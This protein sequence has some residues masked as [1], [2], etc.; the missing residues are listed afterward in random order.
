MPR[1]L[2]GTETQSGRGR[3]WHEVLGRLSGDF[4]LQPFDH[5][6]H[7]L[8]RRRPDAWLLDG[9]NGPLPVREPQVIQLHEA[10]WSEPETLA[11]LEPEFI[12]KV[13]GPSRRAAVAASAVVCPSESAK[14]QIVADC[15]V[16]PERVFV[17]LHGVDHDVFRPG[18]AG[19]PGVASRFGADP[20]RPYVLT[21]ASFH[22]R[23]NL[24]TLRSAFA[25]LSDL[26]HQLVIVGGP[27]HGRTDGDEL[28]A[29]I[30]VDLPNDPRRI[31]V[32]P[33]GIGDGDLAALMCGA[34]AFCLPSLSEGFGL[35][36]AEAMACGTPAV[37]S[38]RGALPEIGGDTAIL[39]EP[40][41]DAIAQGLRPVLVDPARAMA[42]GAACTRRAADFTWDRC[43]DH[44]GVAI[45]TAVAEG[46]KAR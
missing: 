5:V 11:T 1:E 25:Q 34:A 27:A 46:R 24:L 22:P 4:D 41:A 13:V 44:W 9:H 36:A 43:A 21:V 18:L 17:A 2:F 23:K 12:D 31:V 37:L 28:R 6:R 15:G 14:Q 40:T 42:V 29:A 45:R 7:R 16:A 33:H 3:M 20:S 10:P 38:R 8:I 32:V 19:G 39:V 30:C 26:P 35:P